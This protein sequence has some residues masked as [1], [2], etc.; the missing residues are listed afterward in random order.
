MSL[1]VV[2]DARL[3]QVSGFIAGAMGL[4]FPP[5]RWSDLRRGL[6]GAADELGFADVAAYADWLLSE[7]PTQAHLQVLASHLTIGETYFFREKKTLDVFASRILPELI[8][9]R[10]GLDP[11]LRLWSA[12]CCSGEEPYSLAILLHQ[13]LP[14]I[15]DW[16]VTIMATDINPRFLQKAVAGTYGEW[17]FRDTPSGFK[18]H[19]FTRGEGGR[20][21]ILPEIKRLVT[22]EHLNLVEDVYPSLATDTNAMDVIFCRNVLM[23]FTP[24]QAQKVIGKLHSA[25]LEGGHLAVSPSEASQALFPQFVTLNFPG[26]IVYQKNDAKLRD[27]QA[28]MPAPLF[29]A[30]QTGS[31][32]YNAAFFTPAR[33]LPWTPLPM[34]APLPPTA[35]PDKPAPMDSGP[36][37]YALAELLY[38]QGHY[39]EATEKLLA[40]SA[41]HTPESPAF[42]LLTRALANQ[43]K[44]ADALAWCDRWIAADKVDSAGHYLRA[45]VLLEQGDAEQA[46]R[47]LQRAVY[48]H[49]D[50]VL[51]H[52]ALGNLARAGGKPSEAAKHFDNALQLL[53]RHP[54]DAV[55]PESDGL[56]A[57]RLTETITTLS[58]LGATR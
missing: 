29:E 6:A 17:S 2:P 27:G 31:L 10:R 40:L 50:F 11:R 41:E 16:Y 51:A 54:P 8:Q 13:L 25:L 15:A 42:S 18:E 43:G 32:N 58:G 3:S 5:E 12:G 7:P 56:T 1:S 26:V 49:P 4:N 52:F 46:R 9:A 19:Y 57:G 28:S 21:A 44:L 23:Y 48:L 47:S 39:A 38:E 45:V 55:L 22:F 37:P 20:Y 35:S 36:A 34:A 53:A 33:E 30:A 14:D 24:P